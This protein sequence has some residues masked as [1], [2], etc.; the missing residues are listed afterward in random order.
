MVTYGV[1]PSIKDAKEAIFL[2]QWHCA[3]PI[4]WEVFSDM[5][6]ARWE[7]AVPVLVDPNLY[8]VWHVTFDTIQNIP[9]KR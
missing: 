7:A 8:S 5:R 2:M 9:S 3:P 6:V 1:L 4:A